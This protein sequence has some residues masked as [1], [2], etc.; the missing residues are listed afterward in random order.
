MFLSMYLDLCKSINALHNREIDHHS[1][2]PKP[3]Y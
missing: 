3:Y 2:K 1:Q